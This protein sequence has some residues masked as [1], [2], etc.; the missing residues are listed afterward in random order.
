MRPKRKVG[1][2]YLFS[3]PDAPDA[4]LPTQ[5]DL[6]LGAAV[7]AW[8]R[9]PRAHGELLYNRRVTWLELF[10]DLV[11]VVLIAQ[12]THRL[13]ADISVVG[14]F[15]YAVMF[16]LVWLGWLNGSYY[17]E[18]HGQNDGRS[19]LYIFAQMTFLVAM[20]IYAGHA[21]D[22]PAQAIGFGIAYFLLMMLLS[23]QW[24]Y[25]RRIDAPQFRRTVATY[26][27]FL[28]VTGV[29]VL[30]AS[31]IP[32][33]T[34]RTIIWGIAALVNILAQLV[35]VVTGRSDNEGVTD[36]T[37]SWAERM[38]LFIIVVLGE[39]VVG[40][41]D[42][43]AEGE[44][45]FSHLFTGMLMLFLGFAIWWTYFDFIGRREP[46]RGERNRVVWISVHML[47]AGSI[48][49]VGAGM[50]SMI[51]HSGDA[52]VPIASR[53]LIAWSLAVMLLALAAIVTTMP[54]RPALRRT[55]PVLLLGALYSI[56]L[57]MVPLAPVV[58]AVLLPMPLWVAWL[59]AFYDAARGGELIIEIDE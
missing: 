14:V 34:V 56:G 4:P 23:F 1:V 39:V 50:V 38:G 20:T 59:L 6:P 54:R 51:E 48:A 33:N 37:E 58:F 13:A 46:V 53:L 21:V 41:G 11:F 25:L 27:G 42:G 47:L 55:L 22:D 31:F 2:Q 3:M 32:D 18:L 19:R 43:L 28:F 10:Y 8:F 17:Q 44:P 40:V 7:R 5:P 12:I 15:E 24:W 36:V 30:A 26:V 16:G 57:A 35:T 52:V 29:V 49:A 9:R 45:T